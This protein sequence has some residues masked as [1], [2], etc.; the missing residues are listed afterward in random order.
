MVED[1]KEAAKTVASKNPL[2]IVIA[3]DYPFAKVLYFAFLSL[4]PYQ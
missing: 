4:S 3:F 2:D 1:N